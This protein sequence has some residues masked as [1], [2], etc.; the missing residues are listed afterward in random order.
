MD[1]SNL[2][3]NH[4]KLL[5]KLIKIEKS[6]GDPADYLFDHLLN[7]G[8]DYY[9]IM[10]LAEAGLLKIDM[11]SNDEFHVHGISDLG[12]RYFKNERSKEISAMRNT[13]IASVISFFTGAAC[14]RL[15]MLAIG[16]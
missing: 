9:L 16:G 5:K 1:I 7:G 2:T 13:A 8:D 6:G 10:D 3:D 12:R 4:K 11:P 14:D 15:L